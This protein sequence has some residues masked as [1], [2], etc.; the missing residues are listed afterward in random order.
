GHS[1]HF[2]ARPAETGPTFCST[3]QITFCTV[4]PNNMRIR[5]AFFL[6]LLVLTFALRPGWAADTPF[7]QAISHKFPLPPELR[8]QPTKLGVDRDGIVYILTSKG[9]ARLFDDKVAMDRTYRPLVD[10]VP[11]D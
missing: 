1:F 10:K 6:T 3:P 4:Q 5:R 7:I 8:G 2:Q 9:V 11:A